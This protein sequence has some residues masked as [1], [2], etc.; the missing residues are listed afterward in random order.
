MP[1]IRPCSF[2]ARPTNGGP[3]EKARPKHGSWVCEPKLNGWRALVHIPT[4]FMW[5]RHGE[6]LSIEKEFASALA[7]LTTH[8]AEDA[9]SLS[10]IEAGEIDHAVLSCE[11]ANVVKRTGCSKSS[12]ATSSPRASAV[13]MCSRRIC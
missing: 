8:E 3:L 10:I 4:C 2:P 1:A 7:R 6:R 12:R 5:N 9:L 13:W 11:K